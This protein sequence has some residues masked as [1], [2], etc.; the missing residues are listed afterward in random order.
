MYYWVSSRVS[1][2]WGTIDDILRDI[3]QCHV[4]LFFIWFI[5]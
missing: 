3:K 4:E 1:H 2:G 5:E